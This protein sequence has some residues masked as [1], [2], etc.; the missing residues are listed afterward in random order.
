[1]RLTFVAAGNQRTGCGESCG[2]VMALR[3][4][5]RQVLGG[6]KLAYGDQVQGEFVDLDEPAGTAHPLG[7]F[8][9]KQQVAL[10]ALFIDGE[11]KLQGGIP[12]AAVKAYLDEAGLEP[13]IY[14]K[15]AEEREA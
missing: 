9:Q 8:C 7:R 15:T 2:P 14:H 5:I 6:L 3:D 11:L 10:P 13:I 1:V 12:L 4:Q